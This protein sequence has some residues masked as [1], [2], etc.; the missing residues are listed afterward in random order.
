MTLFLV[1]SADAGRKAERCR[2]CCFEA[3]VVGLGQRTFE[4]VATQK[5]VSDGVMQARKVVL[6]FLVCPFH[7]WLLSQLR[8]VILSMGTVLLTLRS[9]LA[10]RGRRA[11]PT[12]E[13]F[14]RDLGLITSM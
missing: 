3:G 6:I 14:A 12:M 11:C 5:P 9:A 8:A 7:W 2:V 1:N 13:H 10:P 4:Q